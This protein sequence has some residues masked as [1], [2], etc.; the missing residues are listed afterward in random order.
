MELF[1]STLKTE[2]YDS[3]ANSDFR[4]NPSQHDYELLIK[5]FERSYYVRD[6]NTHEVTPCFSFLHGEGL[7]CTIYSDREDCVRRSKEFEVAY[8]ITTEVLP[9]SGLWDFFNTC[10]RNGC[11]GAVLDDEFA[12]R[13][14]NRISDLDR[15]LP[16]VYYLR[17]P[18]SENSFT[19][20]FFGKRGIVDFDEGRTI[21]WINYEKSDKL[22]CK[23]LLFD[24][25]LP[26]SQ[27]S[28]C[29]IRGKENVTLLYQGENTFLGPYIS[30]DG[31]VPIFSD[32]TIARYFAKSIGLLTGPQETT[33][34]DGFEIKPVKLFEFLD[35]C[36][37]SAPLTDIVLNPTYHRA[38][39]GHFFVDD[40]KWLLH[41]VSGVWDINET[42]PKKMTNFNLSKGY[43]GAP[44]GSVLAIHGINTLIQYPFKR[45]S[46]A[47][48]SLF[49]EEDANDLIEEEL[50][51][52]H[53]PVYIPK[54]QIPP[55]DSFCID[56]F[57]K[58][59][60][61]RYAFS[62]Y[63]GTCNDLGF[64]IFPDILS[65]ISYISNTLLEVDENARLNGY[66]LCDGSGVSGSGS[67][68]REQ[69][70]TS[71]IRA[72]LKKIAYDA[73]LKG[74][75]PLHSHLIKKL[76]Q[77]VSATC[78]ML[79]RGYF[80]DLLYYDLSDGNEVESRI[81]DTYDDEDE[82]EDA[83]N[84]TRNRIA[85]SRLKLQKNHSIPEHQTSALRSSLETTFSEL[86]PDT[87]S[88]A[89]TALEEFSNVGKRSGYD[90]AGISMKIAKV[91]ERELTIRI[92]RTWRSVSIEKFGKNV[93]KSIIEQPINELTDADRTLSD[94]FSK[95]SKTSL[96]GMRFALRAITDEVKSSS[97]TE[98]FRNFVFSLNDPDWIL[99]DEFSS[100][101]NDISSKYRNGGVHE[102]IVDFV[103]CEDAV[104]RILT[105]KN[106]ALNK[107][108]M[109][110]RQNAD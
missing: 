87:I 98:N 17:V 70:I 2:I 57:D 12:V 84:K 23:Y 28:A 26:S 11:V 52:F 64:L 7:A 38:F 43:M 83:K 29:T 104:S 51:N 73:L 20:V 19:G 109:A 110:T 76:M 37:E 71:D 34:K 56:A 75:S 9:I 86:T 67:K 97:I 59:S 62:S 49:T 54:D 39:Q 8:E 45:V 90:Y 44:D 22:C 24:A 33:F 21:K 65:A 60:G 27:L 106:N 58:V 77:D 85:K 82:D 89:V 40:S 16:T 13:F 1:Q 48:K 94:Y 30:I 32:S 100:I 35:Q 74:Y 79:E 36:A 55:S 53:D 93:I 92:F 107:L 69:N 42:E 47:N 78:E 91:F 88:I 46:G 105:G 68:I 99:S 61:E 5:I 25:P 103:T 15:T 50:S 72:A 101:L 80:G 102:H 10:A 14:F 96:G 6:I 31:A 18:D 95:R 81:L 41:T 4:K 108:I 63:D 66:R 3:F